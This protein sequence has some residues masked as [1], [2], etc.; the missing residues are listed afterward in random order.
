MCILGPR[1]TWGSTRW[2]ES[3]A[4]P[5]VYQYHPFYPLC[6]NLPGQQSLTTSSHSH[7]WA[8]LGP[9]PLISACQAT[10]HT[11]CGETPGRMQGLRPRPAWVYYHLLWCI[12]LNVFAV[13]SLFSFLA[14][15]WLVTRLSGIMS[16]YTI[17]KFS[18]H[19]QSTGKYFSTNLM[20]LKLNWPNGFFAPNLALS[21]SARFLGHRGPLSP[22]SFPRA[23]WLCSIF[24]IYQIWKWIQGNAQML[25]S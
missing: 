9:A 25:R 14:L 23:A 6:D 7:S 21:S 3:K 24:Y 20:G 4:L 10:Q 11:E 18:L 2:L 17:W 13:S 5:G 16:N 19:S 22:H 8:R 15:G 12:Y 1:Y